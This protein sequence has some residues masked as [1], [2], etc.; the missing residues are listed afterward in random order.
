[1]IPETHT[2]MAHLPFFLIIFDNQTIFKKKMVCFSNAWKSSLSLMFLLSIYIW[3]VDNLNEKKI[4][5][6]VI[7]RDTVSSLA[8]HNK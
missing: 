5:E 1:M 7:V 4:Y 3:I 2:T 8:R 6:D